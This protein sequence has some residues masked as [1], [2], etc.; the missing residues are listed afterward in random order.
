MNEFNECQQMIHFSE[1]K[2]NDLKDL[3]LLEAAG[4]WLHDVAMHA[5]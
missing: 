1:A 5:P 4:L 2:T 3:V